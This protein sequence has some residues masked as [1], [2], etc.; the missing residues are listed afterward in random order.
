VLRGLPPSTH[1]D[2]IVGTLTGDDAAVWKRPDG[3][4]LVATVDFFSPLVDDATTWG[5]IG[6]TNSV[7]DIFAMGAT[8]LFALNVVAWPRDEL[9]LDLLGDVLRGASEIAQRCGYIVVGGHTVDGPEPFFGQVVIGTLASES[10]MLTNDAGQ[11]GDELILTKPLGTGVIA[12][13]IKRLPS[14]A[15]EVGGPLHDSYVA[16]TTSMSTPNDVASRVAQRHG[17][18]AAT[19][20]TGFGL[21]G[22]LHK[23]AVASAVV[24]EIESQAL[25]LLPGLLDLIGAGYVPGGTGRNAQFVQPFITGPAWSDPT[26][27]AVLADPQTSG[28]LLLCVKPSEVSGVIDDLAASGVMGVRIGHLRAPGDEPIGSIVAR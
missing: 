28:G 15:I 8:P 22:H 6:A 20:I 16:A 21:V 19:D 25:P 7:S 13:A 5:R 10:L 26:W 27:N 23:L 3:T 24:A 9:P 12:T 17:V 14:A 2:L 11:V 1:P 18:G 4:L